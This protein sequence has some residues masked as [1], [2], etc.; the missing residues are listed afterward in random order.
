MFRLAR[1]S[2]LILTLSASA[3]FAAGNGIWD[4]PLKKENAKNIDS[5]FAGMTSHAVIRGNFKQ[6][7]SIPQLNKE[8]TSTG[9]FVIANGNGILWNTESPFASKLSISDTKMVQVNA[10]GART[11][12]KAE[13][14]IVFAQISK[15]IQAVFS[16]NTAKLQEEFKV[17]FKK[18]GNNWNIGLIPKEASV[19]KAI[20]SIELSGSAWLTTVKLIDGSKSPLLYELTNPKPADKLTAEEQAFFA[21]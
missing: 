7:K 17:F 10:S 12:I 15:T 6:T 19:Q 11:E 3:L 18:Q 2:L 1:N 5:A 4:F 16:G 13:E 14:N 8:F 20:A 9:T 21:K